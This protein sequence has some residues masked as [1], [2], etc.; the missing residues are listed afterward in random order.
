MD[1]SVNIMYDNI[2]FH[3]SPMIHDEVLFSGIGNVEKYR[4]ELGLCMG[5]VFVSS[6]AVIGIII[7]AIFLSFSRLW[8]WIA[9]MALF[10]IVSIYFT[11]KAIKKNILSQT[12]HFIITPS[13]VV[14][15]IGKDYCHLP[16][17]IIEEVRAENAMSENNK[18]SD[19]GTIVVL[20]EN[21]EYS[22]ATVNLTQA[23]N[24]LKDRIAEKSPLP[25]KKEGEIE[26]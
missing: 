21:A 9:V 5:M 22:V 23:V 10:F 25:L 7:A 13:Q 19:T 15:L 1:K 16:M 12:E 6:L 4:N 18:N 17:N 11:V 26:E 14:M 3:S 24:I 20:T 8:M 2:E